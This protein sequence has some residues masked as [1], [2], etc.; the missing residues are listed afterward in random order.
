M[1]SLFMLLLVVNLSYLIWGVAFSEKSS[2]PDVGSQSQGAQTL[3]LLSE[4]LKY[5]ANEAIGQ[6]ST[7]KENIAKL[8]TAEDKNMSPSI[9]PAK[10]CYSL[11][12]ILQEKDKVRLEKS[13]L[14]NGFKTKHKA[15][16]DKEPKSY[17]VYFPAEKTLADARAV[18]SQ[19][20]VAKVK[21]YQIIRKGKFTNAISLGLYN[22]YSRAKI[23]V[24][25]LKKLGFNP[26]VQTRYKQVTRHWLDF[27]ETDAKRLKTSIWEKVQK[28]N[29]LQKLARPCAELL[30]KKG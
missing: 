6:A 11:G 3:M 10:T 15:I 14:Q 17:W 7:N 24:G 20:Q 29:P 5:N 18:V 12:P 23:R 26:K 25:R 16:T 22:G 1:R 19:L 13:L 2:A 27:Q 8:N 21:D 4:Q 30:P 9:G 28:D